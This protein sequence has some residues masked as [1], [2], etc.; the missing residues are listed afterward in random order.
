MCSLEDGQGRWSRDSWPE[1]LFEKT[2]LQLLRDS[3]GGSPGSLLV[4]KW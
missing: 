2:S 1:D 4:L 3:Q